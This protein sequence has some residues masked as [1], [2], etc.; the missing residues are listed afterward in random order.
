MEA[1][2]HR[3]RRF[4]DLHNNKWYHIMNWSLDFMKTTDIKQRK[5]LF[6]HGSV[7]YF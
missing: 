5:I 7:F 6:K 4:Q 3:I 2:E 1:I